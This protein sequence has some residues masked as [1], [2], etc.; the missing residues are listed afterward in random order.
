MSALAL[1]LAAAL[2]WGFHDI[3][4]RFLS[5]RTPITAC[6]MVVLTTGLLF[7]V[8]LMGL[9]GRFAPI[10]TGAVWLATGAGLCFVVAT[11]GLYYA[12]ERGPVK[13]VS[14]LIAT[15]PLLSVGWA[16][17][18]GVQISGPEW[19][20]VLAIV[21]GVSLVA[22]LT[23]PEKAKTPPKGLTVLY[24]LISSVGFAGTFAFGQAAAEVAGD[25]SGTLVTRL[26]AVGLS[27]VIVMAMRAPLWPGRKAV[28]LLVLMGCADGVALYCVLSA[29]GLPDAQFAAVTSSIF[30][31]LT[32]VL[33]WAL[34]KERMTPP[35]W[36]AC[37]LAFAGV[38]YLAL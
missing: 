38:G 16:V 5:Q 19:A 30:G 35:Q 27:L 13:L 23:D 15:Y 14:T 22:I 25:M 37:A 1:G 6:I 17:A 21:V 28:G 26:V 20:A 8:G 31:M 3:C 7:H 18:N 10:E 32:I 11:F 33:A 12:F 29:G 36:L 2:C 9:T 34:L 24:A 4:V